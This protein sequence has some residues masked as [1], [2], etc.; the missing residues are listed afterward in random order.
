MR[1][2]PLSL[3]AL[4]ALSPPASM[5]RGV[6]LGGPW[7]YLALAHALGAAIVLDLMLPRAADAAP[8]DTEFPAAN[9]LLVVL[10]ILSLMA[11][12]VTVWA[13][14]GPSGLPLP[15]R[16]AL[17]FAM[18]FWLAQV[19]HPAAHELIHR[20]KPL[21][22]LGL[23][24]Y[25]A[26]LFGHHTSS[27]RLVH[28]RHVGSNRDPNTAR[29]GEGFY[30]YLRRAWIGSLI[31]GYRAERALRQP[32]PY[33]IYTAG[34]LACLAAGYALAGWPG[35]A[36]WLGLGLHTATQ[37]LL[38]DYVQH[39]GLTRSTDANGR[40]APVTAAHSWNAPHLFSSA[41]TLNATRHSDHHT[42][43]Q[44]P[45]PALHLAPDA[46][47]LPWPLPLACMVALWPPLWHRRMAPLVAKHMLPQA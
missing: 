6:W 12:P 30:R 39:Y 20:P 21:F 2:T 3:F 43:P 26:V 14:A 9:A 32:T 4:A 17:F 47:L 34:A 13:V 22:W 46:P 15:S 18:G 7:P 8:A 33:V 19:T 45:Y 35:L 10:A 5:A 28:H 25:T 24:C 16:A 37:I 23:A 44:R 1:S 40:T 38:S 36:V 42:H 11:L 29:L 41:L 27:H 31:H